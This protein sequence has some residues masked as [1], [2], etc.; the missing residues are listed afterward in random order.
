MRGGGE[1]PPFDR[2]AV[3]RSDGLP[4]RAAALR[5]RTEDPSDLI[6][7]LSAVLVGSG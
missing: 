3:L 2:D 1:T 4:F 5:G 7:D 6:V